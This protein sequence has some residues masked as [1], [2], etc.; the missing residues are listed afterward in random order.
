MSA[1][2]I[3]ESLYPWA[4]ELGTLR[5]LDLE[6]LKPADRAVLAALAADLR[7]AML[8]EAGARVLA[9]R[10]SSYAEFLALGF[11]ELCDDARPLD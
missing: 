1:G 3:S 10:D 11:A 7:D 5:S 4:H 8:R 6:E 9:G 2:E